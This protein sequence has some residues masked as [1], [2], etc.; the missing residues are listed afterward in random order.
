MTLPPDNGRGGASSH[1]WL[2]RIGACG[3]GLALTILGASMLLRLTTVFA[4]DGHAIS[5]LPPGIEYATRLLHRLAASG[6]ALLALCA[7]TLCW[8]RRSSA[9]QLTRPTAWIVASTVILAL[10]G[11]LT[12]GYRLSAI[13][14]VNVTGGMVLLMAFWW[15]RESVITAATMHQPVAAFSW[16]AIIAFVA[17]VGT[18]AAAS[19]WEMH[20]VRW[21]A[22]VHLASLVLC[23]ILIGVIWLEFRRERLLAPWTAALASLLAIQLLVG[24]LMM[25]QDSRPLGL[26]FL[27]A[28]LSSL[29]AM[30]LV[31][32][33]V[34]GSTRFR[35]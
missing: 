35:R 13:T 20:A 7:V 10:I 12:P 29:L 4:L 22:F 32:L 14:V 21:P 3:S 27:H 9:A 5:S 28:M 33:A 25:W 23:L 18:G 11:P 6:V 15:L 2:Q 19:A 1:A 30:A 8:I 34:R 16:A 17:H 31:S 26:T 24:Y